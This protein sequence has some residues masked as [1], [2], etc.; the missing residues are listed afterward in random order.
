M[1]VQQDNRVTV[2]LFGEVQRI[3]LHILVIGCATNIV[4][5]LLGPVLK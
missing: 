4:M 3:L 5:S 1:V 2:T